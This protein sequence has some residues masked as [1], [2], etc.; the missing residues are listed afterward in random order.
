[1]QLAASVMGEG[2]SPDQLRA[3]FEAVTVP[4]MG[5]VYNRALQLTRA[6]DVA[7]DL[8]Q[9]TYLHAFRTFGNFVPDSNAKAWLLTILYSRFIT[10]Y[11]KQT[12]QPD[13]IALDDVELTPAAETSDSG[14]TLDPKLWASEDV[15]AALSQ[16]PDEARTVLLMVDVDDFSYEEVASALNCPVGTVRSRLSRARASTY[17]AL[18]QYARSRG[19]MGGNR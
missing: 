2:R 8:V 19:F 13:A 4:F 11:R 17:V 16:L 6:S 7:A 18:E 9:E 10:R 15:Y 3:A 5:N 14:A 1:L 12:R